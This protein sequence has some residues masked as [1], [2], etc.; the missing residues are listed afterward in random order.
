MP[1]FM[2]RSSDPYSS[3]RRGLG[4]AGLVDRCSAAT[5]SHTTPGKQA[6]SANPADA[7]MARLIAQL[8]LDHDFAELAS[9]WKLLDEPIRAGI[10][11]LVRATPS[12]PAD[13]A[14][15]AVPPPRAR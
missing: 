6:V 7:D 8:T 10:M 13:S 4:Q 15:R 9:V 14:A 5:E 11:A 1:S 2:G 12:R 3:R